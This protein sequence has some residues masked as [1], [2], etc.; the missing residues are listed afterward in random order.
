MTLDKFLT[1][2]KARPLSKEAE[3][4][5]LPVVAGKTS[6]LYRAHAYHTKVPPEGIRPYV[7]HYTEPGHVVLD[8]FCGSGMTGLAAVLEGRHAVLS[9]LSPAAVHIARNYCTPA[10]PAAYRS[11]VEKIL[12]RLSP[13][14]RD[15]YGTTCPA[16]GGDAATEYTVWSDLVACPS[17][18]QETLVWE[19]RNGDQ[20]GLRYLTCSTCGLTARKSAFA[21][22]SSQ[23]VL[24]NRRCLGGCGRVQTQPTDSELSLLESVA[25]APLEPILTVPLD[26][27]REMWRRGHAD[28]AIQTA[29]DFY[30]PRN[31]RVL[32]VLRQAIRDEGDERIRASLLFTFTA[33]VNRASRRYQWNAK[34]PTNVLTGTLYVSSLN[35]EFNVFSL[36]RRK[37]RAIEALFQ[38][39]LGVSNQSFVRRSSAT[40]LDWI[41]DGS[42]D[43]VFTD[44]PFGSNIFY[45]DSSFLWEA[46]LDEF[47][48]ERLEAV[49]N[50]KKP[51]EQGGKTVEDYRALMAAAFSEMRRVLKPG[52][53]ASIVFHNSDDRVWEALRSAVEEGGLRVEDAVAFDKQQPT[54]KG[55]K[56]LMENERV[57]SFDVVLTARR[58]RSESVGS[59]S[60]PD[61]DAVRQILTRHLGSAVE[62][63]HR[64]TAYLHSLVVRTCLERGWALTGLSLQKVEELCESWFERREGAWYPAGS[65]LATQ[66]ELVGPSR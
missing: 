34:R 21:F 42:I 6:S 5:S 52:A 44:P 58:A 43:Y 36:F 31:L 22:R 4:T 27:G 14:E 61:R 56:A 10:E 46:W 1:V 11:A 49:V 24:V 64:T 41:P 50:R 2:S 3:P 26:E 40:S 20:G 23:P 7:R 47:T 48:D 60:A 16:C 57:S 35:Y 19:K 8:P 33:I 18:G 63:R 13:E 28:R 9:D 62:Q 55:V 66:E 17:C 32:A 29:A 59:R 54:F 12:L 30:T 51:A 53:W 45:A 38:A 15:L 37:A 25:A 39:T 65:D